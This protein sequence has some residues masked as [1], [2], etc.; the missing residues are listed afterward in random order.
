MGEARVYLFENLKIKQDSIFDFD[1]LY[2]RLFSWFEVA[3]YDFYEKCYEK[4]NMGDADNLKIYWVATKDVD[5]YTKFVIETSFFVMG[6]KKVEIEK[7]GVKV[8]TNKATMEIRMSVYLVKD[9]EEKLKKKVGDFGRK[10]YEKFVI[11]GR[12]NDQEI[13]LYNESHLL[14]DEVKAFVSMHQF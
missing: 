1:E 7:E 3:G 11:K 10:L 5:D 13:R 14:I 12:L 8:K 4:H 2:K 6:L 9:H